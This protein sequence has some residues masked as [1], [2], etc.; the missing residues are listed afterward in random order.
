MRTRCIPVFVFLLILSLIPS[1]LSPI[2]AGELRTPQT[3]SPGWSEDIDLL[4]TE[5]ERDL[6]SGLRGEAERR[7]FFQAFWQARDPF[8]QTDRNELREEWEGR[9]AQVR[10]QWGTLR[11]DRARAFLLRG[12]PSS[13]FEAKC[14]SSGTFEVWV[15]EPGFREKHRTVLVFLPG[16]G[17]RGG[18]GGN[19]RLWH[20]NAAPDLAAAAAEPCSNRERLSQEAKFIRWAGIDQYEALVQ[21][22][23]ARPKPREWVS[24]FRPVAIDTALGASENAPRLDAGLEIEYAGLQWN[25]VVVR[26]L[27]LVSPQSFQAGSP[28]MPGAA[29]DAHEFSVAGQVLRNGESTESFL[30]RL[31]GRPVGQGVPLAFE[32]Y[33]APGRYTLRIRLEHLASGSV[34]IDDRDIE[35]PQLQT[36]SLPRAVAPLT[37][38]PAVQPEAVQAALKLPPGV[39][40]SA[41]APPDPPDISHAL[42]EADAALSSHR[43]GLRL[44][45]PP[46]AV[47]TGNARFGVRL[48]QAADIPDSERIDRVAWFLDGKP[49]L[50]RNNPP[51]DL[52][53]D[54]GAV[55][56]P[57]KLRAEGLGADGAVL[58]RDE[59][60]V[61]AGAQSFRV[62]LLEPRPGRGYR[63][64]LRALAEVTPPT[65]ASVEKVEIW[66]GEDL[67]AT[68]YQPPYALPLVLP[69]EGEAGY[70]RAVAWL[71]G[72]GT[73]EDLVFVNT[74]IEPDSMDVHMVELYTT[75]LD[76]QGRPVTGGI[77]PGVFQVTE[78]GV[79]QTL[80]QVDQV[81]DTPVRLVTLIDSSASMAP[82][83][84]SA[85]QAALGFLQG[86]LRPRDQAAVIAFNSHPQVVVPL[87]GDLE[88]L[89][90]GLQGMLAE[91]DTALYDSLVYSLL[92]LTEA[93]G[94]R[95]VLL[96]SDGLDRSSRLGFDQALEAA[97][98]SGIAVYAIGL[99]LPTGAKGEAGQRLSQLAG[100]TGGRTFFADDSSQLAGVYAEI[101]RELRA[102]YKICYQSSNNKADGSF[103][104]VQVKL[105]RSGMEARTISGYYP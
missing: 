77:D 42:A 25:K 93:K 22:A 74:P 7:M 30:Y 37:P 73:S 1:F 59:M 45:F 35:V 88:R 90:E 32:R 61:N 55:P 54:L 67:V 89:N 8:P 72:G 78:N 96:L 99:G 21:R 9:L 47:L 57:R 87:T 65:G 29:V 27:M 23:L 91:D 49:L 58:A 43:P 104:N 62:R 103:R 75:V 40:E 100:V 101:E 79:R 50:T 31:R 60:L 95:A 69:R 14:P 10:S 48:D 97:R 105:A 52:S 3:Q 70:V 80:R 38:A 98:R 16:V 51:F 33:L 36:A 12:E 81:G 34:L 102:Q 2:L 84:Q 5:R 20:P 17:G 76:G 71:A 19:A 24:T 63:R 83:M 39:S 64:G 13:R 44:L 66:F 86:L 28:G 94:Q 82:Q 92:Y 18:S 4:A 6:F 68:L 46:G 26:V 85:R 53:I 15:Y 56:R 41:P 11:D